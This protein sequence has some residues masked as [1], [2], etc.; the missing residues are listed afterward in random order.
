MYFDQRVI[1][2]FIL[3]IILLKIKKYI[4]YYIQIQIMPMVTY[5]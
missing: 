3:Y 2:I 5:N 4:L 1:D